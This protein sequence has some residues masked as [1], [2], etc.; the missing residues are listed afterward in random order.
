ME[1]D[2]LHGTVVSSADERGL[3][4]PACEAVYAVL[5]PCPLGAG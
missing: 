1:L 2:A 5:R 3:S 4:V